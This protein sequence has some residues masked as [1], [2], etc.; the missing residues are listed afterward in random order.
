MEEVRAQDI[1]LQDFL[2]VSISEY[3]RNQLPFIHRSHDRARRAFMG[4]QE[5]KPQSLIYDVHRQIPIYHR[6]GSVES[7]SSTLL[8]QLGSSW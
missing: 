5:G 7:Y 2:E 1:S 8:L 4:E 6:S 3:V